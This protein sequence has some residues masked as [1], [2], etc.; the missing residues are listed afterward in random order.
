MTILYR[1]IHYFACLHF[2][3]FSVK[4]VVTPCLQ[5]VEKESGA[6]SHTAMLGGG[7]VMAGDREL[8][9]RGN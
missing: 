1:H 4:S 3:S 8:E 6:S 7:G 9:K 5:E 2:Q